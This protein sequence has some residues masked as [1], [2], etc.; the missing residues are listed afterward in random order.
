[1]LFLVVAGTGWVALRFCLR[2][3]P[4]RRQLLHMAESALLLWLLVWKISYLLMDLPGFV[5]HPA[6]VLYFDGGIWGWWLAHLSAAVYVGVAGWRRQVGAKDLMDSAWVFVSS[7]WAAAYL[8]LAFFHEG[9]PWRL[10]GGAVLSL[11]LLADFL[12]RARRMEA[13]ES[14]R[15]AVWFSLGQALWGFILPR[16]QWWLAFSKEQVLLLVM[17]AALITWSGIEEMLKKGPV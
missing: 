9:E 15:Y 8:F 1:M 6:A 4:L 7:G 3:H 13:P 11:A 14:R 16:E 5:E 17:A 12:L 2:T 10:V